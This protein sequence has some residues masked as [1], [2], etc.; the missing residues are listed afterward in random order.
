MVELGE[1]ELLDLNSTPRWTAVGHAPFGL[2]GL[3]AQNA[4]AQVPPSLLSELPVDVA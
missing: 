2:L 4:W 3:D 1:G